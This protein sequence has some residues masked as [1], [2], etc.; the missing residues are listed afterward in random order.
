MNKLIL[1]LALAAVAVPMEAL[2][3]GAEPVVNEDQIGPVGEETRRGAGV[4]IFESLNPE[5][6][7]ETATQADDQDYQSFDRF[8]PY[9]LK[10]FRAGPFTVYPSVT[11]GLMYDDNVFALATD[12][13]SDW[14]Y[15]AR[16]QFTMRSN[17]WERTNMLVEGFLEVRDYEEFKSEDQNNGAIGFA[18]ETLVNQNTQLVTRGQYVHG[19]ESRGVS[20]NVFNLFFEPIAYDQLEGAAALNKRWGRYWA[21]A[22]GSTLQI[23]YQDAI[24]F[25]IPISQDYRSGDIEKVPLRVG[26]V[27]APQ[28]S[29]FVE[30][31]YTPAISRSITSARKAIGSSAVSCSSPGTGKTLPAKSSSAT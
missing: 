13:L 24:L 15:I 21:S 8:D 29:V 3:Q 28:T 12:P 4:N 23:D 18:T 17:G 31:A 30:G 5:P 14:I 9:G 7:T 11:G 26:Y 19:H 6:P 1:G 20:R 22:G 2:A 25:G 16:P 27:V 10:G